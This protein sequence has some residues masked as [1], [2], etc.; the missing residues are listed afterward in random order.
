MVCLKEGVMHL[1]SLFVA[2]LTAISV[3]LSSTAMA[4]TTITIGMQL[5]P[6]NLDPTSGAA[7]AIDEV[8]YANV[9]EGLTRY[10]ADGSIV[11]ALAKSWDIS[12]DGLVYT[13]ILHSGVTFHDGSAFDADDVKFSLD[14][15]RADDSTNAQKR[16]FTGIQSVEVITPQTVRVTLTA[17]DGGFITNLAWGDA[18][19]L[20]P[21]SVDLAKTAPIGTGP[22]QFS[23]WMQGDRVELVKNPNYW[24]NPVA[25]DRA[26]FKF[27]A[28][29]T[30]AFA[31]MMAGDIDAFPGY[32]APETLP[33]LETDPRFQVMVG[34]TE[35][36]TI[37]ST[38]NKSEKLRDIRVRKA[39]AHAINR[40]AIIEGAMFGYGT[41]I[42]THFA[43]H[44][45]D[46]LDLTAQSAYDPAQ[47]RALLKEALK[48][49]G[50]ENLSLS[51]KLPPP[52][53]A[54][55]GGEIIAAQLR[56]VGISTVIENL[57][58]AQWLEQVFRG[59][60][61]DLTIV[62]HTEPMDIGIYANPDYYFQYDSAEFQ[63]LMDQLKIA[64]DPDQRSVLLAKAQRRIADD[65]VNG[66]LFQL[67]RTGVANAKIKGLWTNAPTQANDLTAVRWAE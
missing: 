65:Y 35:G 34:S 40:Q 29:P 50:V 9:F 32:P 16:L 4:K 52:S 12:S 23:K 15:A 43:P 48:D 66:F 1:K 28:D 27:I 56:E 63:S 41:P 33:Q 14:R 64:S 44:H 8:V 10:Q 54:R 51:L 21:E 45:P 58:W 22:F 55:R 59:K 18:V 19:I 61:Y 57:E 38:N 67:A 39:I 11:P 5:E 60:D 42:G 46:Y 25:L 17:P 20:A 31:A 2:G 13:F 53:Y 6:P 30:A 49:A 3:A 62:S 26:V 37:L 47:S 36:E 7:A 24:G